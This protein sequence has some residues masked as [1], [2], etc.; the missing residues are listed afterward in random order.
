VLPFLLLVEQVVRLVVLELQM[1]LMAQQD[2]QYYAL[3]KIGDD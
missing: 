3:F 1:E 2:Y